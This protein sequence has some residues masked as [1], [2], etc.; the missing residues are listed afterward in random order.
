MS[1]FKVVIA[2]GRS[3]QDLGQ[4]TTS[5]D[6]LLKAKI[7]EGHAIT[8]IS[9]TA[10]GADKL[11]EEYAELRGFDLIQ[12]PAQWDAYGKSAGYRRNVD[13]A[14]A[15]DGIVVFWDGKSKGSKHMIDI[16]L[17]KELPTKT[18]MY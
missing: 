16:G 10:A 14:D 12:M 8:V 2:G 1:T 6:R 5:M 7:A 9:G 17:R 18:V 13:M 3:F 4:M 11:G 15:C